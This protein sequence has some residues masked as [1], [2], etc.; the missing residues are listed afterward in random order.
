[1]RVSRIS[2]SYFF[3][4]SSIVTPGISGHKES[5]K[6]N[7]RSLRPRLK[8]DCGLSHTKI[9]GR[10]MCQGGELFRESF[11]G[12][13]LDMTKWSYEMIMSSEPN[14]EFVV[15]DNQLT[16]SVSDGSF[17]IKPIPYED[18]FVRS[19]RLELTSCT[20]RQFTDECVKSARGF[21]I[22]PPIRSAR[23]TTKNSFAFTYGKVTVRA[24]L[25]LGD[26]ILPEIWLEPKRRTY[27][28]SFASGRIR[29]AVARGNQ[30]LIS[31]QK[32][33][34]GI[35]YL[36]SGIIMGTPDKTRARNTFE[37]SDAGWHSD[38]HNFTLIWKPDEISFMIDGENK[39]AIIEPQDDRLSDLLG[40]AE[41][42]SINWKYGTK[43]AP[44]DHDFYIS[45]GLSVGG[46]KDFPD[47]CVSGGHPKPWRNE[48]VKAMVNFWQDREH[49]LPTWSDKSTFLV[50][51]VTVHAL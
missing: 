23:I 8:R 13:S 7:V 22:L 30:D 6:E 39:E 32:Q 31:N 27:G 24:K 21:S 17:K 16:S 44:F 15:L 35:N 42:E 11:S 12:S 45:L 33:K 1:M 34:I 47:D 40:F 5:Q 10:A 3:V 46:M 9:D 25:P 28:P 51:E 37:E 48:A 2:W 29:I 38:F 18:E 36:Q 43:I 41:N 20:G 49:W 19:G 26:W 50:D 4:L 14:Y